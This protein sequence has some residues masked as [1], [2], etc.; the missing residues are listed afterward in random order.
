MSTE[1]AMILFGRHG[2]KTEDG[3]DITHESKARVYAQ[4][5]EV[6]APFISEEGVNP[7]YI[8]LWSSPRQRAVRTG[9]TRYA[10]ALGMSLNALCGALDNPEDSRW[11]PLKEVK[12]DSRL[13]FKDA[14]YNLGLLKQLE[15]YQ[16]GLGLTTL[17][18]YALANPYTDTH[19]GKKITPSIRRMQSCA[20]LWADAL[21]EIKDGT[22]MLQ[23]TSHAGT[24]D[25][26]TAT[27]FNNLN[28]SVPVTMPEQYGGAFKEED[29]VTLTLD[30]NTKSGALSNPVFE[31][32]GITYP[33]DLRDFL[34]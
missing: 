18:G 31:R 23:M 15:G 3:N 14:E 9:L 16:K 33:V 5:K 30:R 17:V 7:P 6:I 25:M 34:A 32:D 29:F 10:P 26:L 19:E 4:G 28:E 13:D 20:A 11:F 27:L 22:R 2:V 24:I 21:R 12:K 8:S 1:R